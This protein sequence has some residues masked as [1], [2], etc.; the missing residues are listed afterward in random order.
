[1]IDH[2]KREQMVTQIVKTMD[3][4]F[5][6]DGENTIQINDGDWQISLPDQPASE[7]A[8]KV[9]QKLH[10]A[11]AADIGIRFSGIATLMGLGVTYGGICEPNCDSTGVIIVQKN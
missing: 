4:E 8:I 1:M 9:N 5:V 7:V 10:P 6:W 11:V 2:V 3:C